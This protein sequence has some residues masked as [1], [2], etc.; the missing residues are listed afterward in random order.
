MHTVPEKAKIPVVILT[1]KTITDEVR[2]K[3]D[4]FEVS[5]IIMKPYESR[6][7]VEKIRALVPLT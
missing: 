6:H 4:Q 2:T 1:G 3:A 7:F 5:A